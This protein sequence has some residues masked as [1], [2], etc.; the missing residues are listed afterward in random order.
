NKI[1]DRIAAETRE[2]ISA[3]EAETAAKCAEIKASYDKLAQ[4]E[5]WELIRAGAKDCEL[6]VSRLASTAAMESK[7]SVL[8]MKQEAVG[9]VFKLATQQICNLPEGEYTAF[10][11]KLAGSAAIYGTEEIIFNQRDKET[12]GKAVTKAAND[13]LKKRGLPQKLTI[14]EQTGSFAG[15]LIVKQ[16]DIET[17]CCVEKLVE[18]SRS[19]LASKIAEVLF[20]D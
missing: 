16:G 10:L 19:Q 20:A 18:L 6:Q 2:E 17:N 12:C 5:Y 11:A 1:T 7:K 15:G 4:D 3:L 8:S 14:C 13:L 9:E